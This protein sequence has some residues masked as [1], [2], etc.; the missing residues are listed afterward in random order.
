MKN[1]IKEKAKSFLAEYRLNEVTL[2]DLRKII[3]L[4]GYTIIEFNHI[5][6]DENVTSLIEA[7]NIENIVDKSRGFTYA[8]RHRRLVFLHEDLSDDEKR[9]V[10]AHEEG[11]IYCGHL[12][13]YPIIGNDVVEEHEANEFTHYILSGSNS[14]KIKGFVEKNKMLCWIVAATLVVCISGVFVIKGI[15][16]ERSYYGEYYITSSGNKYHEKKCIFV[17]DKDNIHRMT[18]EE[19]ESGKYGPCD[20]CLPQSN[21][22]AESE[23]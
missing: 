19:F 18:I 14:N 1:D 11:H 12:S 7:L 6:N 3:K 17:K 22:D 16:R 5:F 20:I 8:D 4:Q 15:Q 21:T 23:K 13:S 9:L 2:E 10:L